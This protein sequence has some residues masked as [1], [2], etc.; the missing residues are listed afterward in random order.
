MARR[1]AASVDRRDGTGDRNTRRGRLRALATLAALGQEA[2][3][4]ET[5]ACGAARPTRFGMQRL[6]YILEGREATVNRGVMHFDLNG[7]D[8]PSANADTRVLGVAGLNS[9]FAQAMANEARKRRAALH[10][11]LAERTA[12]WSP[13]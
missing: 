1:Q 7:Y 3:A 5:W 13:T 12:T 9:P 6:G 11:V 2:E 4:P 8:W 10:R